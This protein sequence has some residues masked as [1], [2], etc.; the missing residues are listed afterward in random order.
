VVSTIAAS[1]WIHS[2]DLTEPLADFVILVGIELYELQLEALDLAEDHL[3]VP[4]SMIAVTA[5][6]NDISLC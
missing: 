1:N 2:R 6:R 3:P 5:K 4:L